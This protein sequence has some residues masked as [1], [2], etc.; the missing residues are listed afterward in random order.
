[1]KSSFLIFALFAMIFLAQALKVNIESKHSN[2]H[3]LSQVAAETMAHDIAE[4]LVEDP[5]LLAEVDK[6]K[7]AQMLKKALK[8][9]LAKSLEKQLAAKLAKMSNA[10]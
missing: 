9:K 1:M 10:S 8:S 4:T 5:E 3:Q 7:L 6:G 2:N